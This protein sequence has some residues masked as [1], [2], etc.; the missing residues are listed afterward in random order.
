MDRQ[1]DRHTYSHAD[2]SSH[3]RYRALGPELIPVYRQSARRWLTISHPP[4]GRLSLL[5]ARLA[6]TFPAAEHHRSLP[7]SKLYCLVIEANRCEQLAQGCY[8]ALLRVEFEPTTCWS[9]VQR[10][11]RCATA[12]PFYDIAVDN[13]WQVESL[14]A[15]KLIIYAVHYGVASH[16]TSPSI[17]SLSCCD[18]S[19]THRYRL[20]RSWSCL[21]L[22]RANR[23][24]FK[25]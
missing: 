25:R 2:R 3:T 18:I 16:L 10:S 17:N 24:N 9:Q 13:C 22:T 19:T 12:P 11:T 7:G 4:G 5:S 6:V 20:E 8:T 23:I 15:S 1:T 21:I 14:K